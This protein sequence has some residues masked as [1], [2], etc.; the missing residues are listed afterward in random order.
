MKWNG[1]EATTPSRAEARDQRYPKHTCID[2]G[3][4]QRAREE[5]TADDISRAV[6]SARRLTIGEVDL[7]G[8][9]VTGTEGATE[10]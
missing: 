5:R 9:I 6:Y 1:Y 4:Q 10:R 7:V 2:R 8:V 3:A